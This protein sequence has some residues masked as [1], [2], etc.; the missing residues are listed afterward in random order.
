MIHGGY[1]SANNLS[2]R[3]SRDAVSD[4]KSAATKRHCK[5]I[6]VSALLNH[7][8]EELLVGT[9][10]QVRLRRTANAAADRRHQQQQVP[11]DDVTSGGSYRAA[12][13]GGGLG[14]LQRAV[15]VLFRKLVQQPIARQ[16]SCDDLFKP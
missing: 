4:G 8:V 1:R 15:F 6:E 3:R 10:R 12:P 16:S 11:A 2:S 7:R 9:L 5:F 13:T 14:C